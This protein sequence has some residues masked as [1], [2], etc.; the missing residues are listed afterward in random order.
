MTLPGSSESQERE[1]MYCI[2]NITHS[3]GRWERPYY[4]TDRGRAS[5]YLCWLRDGGWR[6]LH[7]EQYR[8]G[9]WHDLALTGE[10]DALMEG[11]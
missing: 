3:H 10:V 8:D 6:G 7:V 1:G 2:S 9:Q 11:R 4:T 5:D